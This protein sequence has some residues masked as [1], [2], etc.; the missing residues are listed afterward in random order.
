VSVQQWQ[1]ASDVAHVAAM[2][3]GVVAY[4]A[5]HGVRDAVLADVA[6]A[7]SEVL[8][9]VALHGGAADTVSTTAELVDGDF[10][11]A[12]RGAGF[13]LSHDVDGPAVRL[14]MVIAAA[15]TRNLRVASTDSA[16]RQISMRFP[17]AQE[18]PGA[19]LL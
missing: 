6:L 11:V 4:A 2:R 15:L 9:N 17:L 5:E 12:I 18:R 1:T 10:V 8:T 3:R 14:G 19:V 13:G 7:V 16:R